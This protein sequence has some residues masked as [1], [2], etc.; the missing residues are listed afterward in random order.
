MNAALEAWE[1][2]VS[3]IAGACITEEKLTARPRNIG[4]QM[5]LPAVFQVFQYQ[6]ASTLQEG[7]DFREAN[8]SIALV[9]SIPHLNLFSICI[10]QLHYD[11][12]HFTLAV[13]YGISHKHCH[14]AGAS[15]EFDCIALACMFPSKFV[16]YTLAGKYTIW[17]KLDYSIGR[18]LAE[19]CLFKMH[20][21]VRHQYSEHSQP[22]VAMLN[23]SHKK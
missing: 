3:I 4:A 20:L 9:Q 8:T 18:C 17:M 15:A 21:A 22:Y 7:A 11:L 14:G 12:P 19:P 16:K 13:Q 5:D 23:G 2:A 6:L 1:W 10:H